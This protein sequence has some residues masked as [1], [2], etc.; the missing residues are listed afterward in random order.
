MKQQ[1]IAVPNIG[2]GFWWR[3]QYSAYAAQNSFSIGR[4]LKIRRKFC[5]ICQQIG[6]IRK[7]KDDELGP[8]SRGGGVKYDLIEVRIRERVARDDHQRLGLVKRAAKSIMQDHK[9][10]SS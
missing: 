6:N 8:P 4:D 7:T 5:A 10:Y 9:G 3:F 2:N 1:F